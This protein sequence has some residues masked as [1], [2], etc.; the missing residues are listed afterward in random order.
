M[1]IHER[2]SKNYFILRSCNILAL[3]IAVVIATVTF[4]LGTYTSAIP[5]PN[6]PPYIPNHPNPANG[7]INVSIS[8]KLNWTGGD[9]DNN[10][11]TYDV[12]F[13]K[14]ISPPKIV[15][16]QSA[17]LYNPGTMN[18]STHYYWKI[19]ARD[20][21]NASTIGPLWSFTTE[22]KPNSPPNTPSSPSPANGASNILLNAILKWTGGDPDGD[23]VKYDVYF[24]QSSSP[25]KV[26]SNQSTLSYTPTLTYNTIYYWKIVAWDNHSASTKGPVWSFTTKAKPTVKITIPL[27]NTLYIQGKEFLVNKLPIATIVY[28]PINITAI[29]SASTQLEKVEFFIDGVSKFNDTTPP[30]V[31]LWNPTVSFNGLSLTH[32]IKVIVTDSEGDK[33]NDELNV[34]KWRFHPLPFI[35]GGGTIGGIIASKFLLHTTVTGLFFNVQQSLFTTSFY[36]LR[37]HY[38]TS[39]PIRHE[40]GVVNFRSCTGGMI[41][42]PISL[43]K[44]GPSHNLVYGTFTFLGDIHYT[45]S[46]F[47]Q[48]LP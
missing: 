32:T 41:I 36:A 14:T 12:Y 33:A 30:Y 19:V 45:R 10:P 2:K 11:V 46:S 43:L 47:G 24:G 21:Q 38:W 7:S 1:H 26:L 28:G 44:I 27:K 37:I 3:T 16:N 25:S 20:N 22:P 31:Y 13:G 17:L 5:S 15:S 23:P 6:T 8:A 42:G 18:Y 29:A 9:P 40:K 34:T 48:G 4:P 39:G 35:I